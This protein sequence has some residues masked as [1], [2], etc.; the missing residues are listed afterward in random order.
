VAKYFGKLDSLSSIGEPSTWSWPIM[1]K[2]IL[3]ELEEWDDFDRAAKVLAQT[4]GW[5]ESQRVDG[6]DARVGSFTRHDLHLWLVFDDVMGMAL[7]CEG[8]SSHLSEVGD[9][10]LSALNYDKGANVN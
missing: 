5:T 2:H 3:Q 6:P 7:K 1:K 9:A 8:D 4:L 10:I